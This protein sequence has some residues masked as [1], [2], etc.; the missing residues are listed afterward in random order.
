MTRMVMMLLMVRIMMLTKK[1]IVVLT[2]KMIIMTIGSGV[3]SHNPTYH[4]ISYQNISQ[5]FPNCVV[6]GEKYK[7]H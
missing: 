1:M 4:Q 7:P 2:M 3:T 6:D 5:Y